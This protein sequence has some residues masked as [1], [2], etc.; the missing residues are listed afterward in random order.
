MSL[1]IKTGI[2]YVPQFFEIDGWLDEPINNRLHM[3]REIIDCVYRGI[4][5]LCLTAYQNELPAGHIIINEYDNFI[6]NSYYALKK[7][8]NRQE[9]NVKTYLQMI[10]QYREY[11][12]KLRREL[13]A[14]DIISVAHISGLMILE[15]YRNQGL[16]KI[17]LRMS[18]DNLKQEKF[19]AV[20]FE[21]SN[22]I[23]KKMAQDFGAKKVASFSYPELDLDNTIWLAF[24]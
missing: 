20:V 24:C 2:E 19:Q 16:A 7:Y 13:K 1:L 11:G 17:L 8:S 14:K 21:T 18:R 5:E 6:R 12:L 9:E 23:V 10:K 22:D 3:P 4:E 15:E